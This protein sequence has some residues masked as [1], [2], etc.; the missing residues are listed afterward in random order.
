MRYT[1]YGMFTRCE[2]EVISRTKDTAVIKF[3]GINHHQNLAVA[4]LELIK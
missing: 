3:P 1:L 4:A 2:G